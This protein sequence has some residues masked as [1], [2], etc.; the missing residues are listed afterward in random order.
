MQ[1]EELCSLCGSRNV[2]TVQD[3]S[4]QLRAGTSLGPV[5]LPLPETESLPPEQKEQTRV[6]ANMRSDDIFAGALLG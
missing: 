6:A 3:R 5:V 4:G 1:C 2:D